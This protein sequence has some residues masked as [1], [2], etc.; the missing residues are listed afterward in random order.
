M[1]PKRL[2]TY[3]ATVGRWV[4]GDTVDLIVDLGFNV[5]LCH[6]FRLLDINTPERGR[7]GWQEATDRVNAI[8][9]QG[10]PVRIQTFPPGLDKYGRYLAV[11]SVSDHT[12]S[13]NE[14]LLEEGLA[15]PYGK[16]A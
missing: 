8:A 5:K 1:F 14:I 9:P 10:W 7:D 3:D 11:V 2:Y 13:I 15:V 6:R 16:G 12:R 4:D